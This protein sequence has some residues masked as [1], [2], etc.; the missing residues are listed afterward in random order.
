M[1]SRRACILCRRRPGVEP[2]WRPEVSQLPAGMVADSGRGQ[3]RD[4]DSKTVAEIPGG[5][6]DAQIVDGGPQVELRSRRVA[7]EATV[8]MAAEM[9]GE[10][11]ALHVAVAMDRARATQARTTAGRGHEAQQVQHLLDGD[12]AADLPRLIPGMSYAEAWR[13]IVPE[14]R[15]GPG[16]HGVG[17][18]SCFATLP[19]LSGTGRLRRAARYE[20]PSIFSTIAPSTRRS[21]MAMAKGASPR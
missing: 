17:L 13:A 5:G 21:R 9:D 15:R 2:V 10:D 20:R 16:I 7:T 1:N 18:G 19:S 4:R 3:V 11:P 6:V 8:A 12:L 14:Q